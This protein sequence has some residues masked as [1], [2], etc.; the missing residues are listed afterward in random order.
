M[1]VEGLTIVNNLKGRVHGVN[2]MT[3]IHGINDTIT[4]LKMLETL[5]D[6]NIVIEETIDR[7][8]RPMLQKDGG[9]LELINVSGD[10]VLIS[11][12]GMCAQCNVA[13]FTMKDVVE[14][15]LREFVDE[16]IKVEEAK[17]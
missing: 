9:D 11:F 4:A 13:E 14:A 7:E 12:R 15:R 5:V 3:A 8:I 17:A 2:S 10:R 6:E 1:S 16:R